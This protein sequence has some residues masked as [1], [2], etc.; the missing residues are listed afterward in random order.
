MRLWFGEDQAR[1]VVAAPPDK[2]D[3]IHKAA[4]MAKVPVRL[5]GRVGGDSIRLQVRRLCRLPRSEPRMRDWLPRF[6]AHG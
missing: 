5:L 1:I 2:A 6:I 4:A 3:V